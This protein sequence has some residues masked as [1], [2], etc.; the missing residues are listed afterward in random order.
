MSEARPM[1]AAPTRPPITYI[2]PLTAPIAAWLRGVGITLRSRQV[3][4][5]GWYSSTVP[6]DMWG[7]VGDTAVSFD[8][9]NVLAP[10]I[11]YILSSTTAASAAPR[12][13][14]IGT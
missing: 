12:L 2:F 9:G 10:P 5:A 11:T 8:P 1:N 4:A 6:T 13:L 7:C 3:F 14:G